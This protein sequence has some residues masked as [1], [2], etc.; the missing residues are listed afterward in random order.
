MNPAAA[1]AGAD[2]VVIDNNLAVTT[3]VNGSALDVRSYDGAAKVGL[4]VNQT[5]G[6]TPTLDAKIQE[7]ATSGGTYTDVVNGA[8]TQVTT[9]DGNQEIQIPDVAQL[10]GFIRV[11]YATGGTSPAYT[12]TSK[13]VSQKKY[14]S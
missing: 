2:S 9:V 10:K 6:T 12:V 13:F 7:S 8:F 1:A 14:R 11:A 4:A 5:A 3:S